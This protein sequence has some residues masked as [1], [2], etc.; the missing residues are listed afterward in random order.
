M[1][2]P[3]PCTYSQLTNDRALLGVDRGQIVMLHSSVK[4]VGPVICGPNVIIQAILDVL[5]ADGTLMMY[6]GWQDIPDFVGELPP[7]ERRIWRRI[8]VLTTPR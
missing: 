1:S 7:A 8:A 3:I 2:A 6:A 5:G 4:A